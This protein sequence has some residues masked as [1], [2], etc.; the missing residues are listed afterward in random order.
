MCSVAE[1]EAF[2]N[3][4]KKRPKIVK[5]LGGIKG[6]EPVVGCRPCSSTGTEGNA[7]AAL[8]DSDPLEVVLCTNRLNKNNLEEALTHEL[9]HAYDFSNN[10]T[11]F[12]Y[13]DGLAYAEIRA[14]R[15]AECRGPFMFEWMRDRCIK[16]HA[17]SSTKN[18]FADAETCVKR[19]YASAMADEAP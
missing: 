17:T 18:F 14:A 4:L 1:C 11:D 6:E 12:S 2:V 10:R 19:S 9:V 15:Y 16:E 7:R 5:L 13:C 8:F 3:E